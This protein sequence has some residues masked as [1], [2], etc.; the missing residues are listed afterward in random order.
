MLRHASLPSSYSQPHATI[1][2]SLAVTLCSSTFDGLLEVADALV[3]VA[4]LTSQDA[5]LLQSRSLIPRLL[6]NV[7]EID[8]SLDQDP[9]L[10]WIVVVHTC[11]E[12]QAPYG[13]ALALQTMQLQCVSESILMIHCGRLL[14]AKQRI[15]K[16]HVE[17]CHEFPNAVGALTVLVVKEDGFSQKLRPGGG[18]GGRGISP[19]RRVVLWTSDRTT[20]KKLVIHSNTV[21]R[22]CGA[23]AVITLLANTEEL[24]VRLDR[25]L[26]L[27]EVVTQHSKGEVRPTL[28]SKLRSAP[29]REGQKL[30][31]LYSTDC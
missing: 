28:F 29:A 14:L 4:L 10:L 8:V 21:V 18:G 3:V 16:P 6:Q 26:E 2:L 22:K 24:V 25:L 12:A 27:T 5:Q 15:G 23:L 17:V 9:H 11:T 30:Q 13:Q 19:W 31:I 7:A 1:L 20:A